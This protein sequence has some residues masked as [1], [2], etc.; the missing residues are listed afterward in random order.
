MNRKNIIVDLNLLKVFCAIWDH[1]SLTEAAVSLGLTQPAVSHALRRLRDCLDD[2][3]FVR[4]ENRMLPTDVAIRLHTPIDEALTL[5]RRALQDVSDFDPRA[6]ERTFRVAMSDGAEIY[7][8]Q[9]LTRVLSQIAPS[10]RIHVVPLEPD[11]SVGAMRSG[12]IDV[13]IGHISDL[14][15]DCDSV[16]AF[17]DKL[18]CMVRRGHRLAQSKLTRENFSKLQF[19]HARMTSPVH[20]LVER[21]LVDS[22]ARSQISV[23]GHFSLA[24][25]IVR[26]SDLAAIFPEAM[27][28]NLPNIDDFC[29]CELPFELPQIEVKVHI[30]RRFSRDMGILWLRGMIVETLSNPEIGT[31]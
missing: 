16:D 25:G 5:I 18:I 28:H 19:F 1:R 11:S 4:S 12:E 10:V 23:R 14:D 29:L 22:D 8:L 3:L 15:D 27:A 31:I 20:Q 2:P 7:V 24:P 26:E 13:S 30:H 17:N 9:R 21:W 6:S